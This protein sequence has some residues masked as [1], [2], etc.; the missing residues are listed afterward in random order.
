MKG[1]GFATT[2]W[3]AVLAAGG[4]DAAAR[5]ALAW[6]CEAYWQPLHDHVRRRGHDRDAA[7]D[8]VQGFFARLL[9]RR[10]LA[11]DPERGRFRSYLLG[12]LDHFLANHH[13]A[14]RALKRGGGRAIARLDAVDEQSQTDQRSPERAFARAWARSLL[15]QA[16]ARLAEDHCDPRRRELFAAIA[17]FLSGNAPADAYAAIGARL[18]MSEGAVKVAVHRL[19]RRYR[20]VLRET[21]AETLED[22]GAE[23]AIEAELRDLLEA[24]RG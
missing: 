15:D 7:Q 2:R 11:A 18:G 10:D 12:A 21:V 20:D 5:K 1:H 22:P 19:R 4:D 24:L 3:S 16:L 8:L 9:E 14:E 23:G 17:P 13:D 6:L